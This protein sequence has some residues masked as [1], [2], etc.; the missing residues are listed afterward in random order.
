MTNPTWP[1]SLPQ[2]VDVANFARNSSNNVIES[3]VDAGPAKIRRRFTV[4]SKLLVVNLDMTADQYN[5][6]EDFFEVGCLSGAQPFTWVDPI[7]QATATFRFRLPP[8]QLTALDP[9]FFRLQL[10]LELMP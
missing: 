7:S 5:T 10:N 9:N 4:K 3:Q 6:F 2:L 8:P 1:L